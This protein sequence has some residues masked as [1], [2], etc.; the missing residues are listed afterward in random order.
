MS[1]TN[2]FDFGTVL[3]SMNDSLEES[4]K[5]LFVPVKEEPTTIHVIGT[6]R[7][8]TTLLTQ[9][10]LSHFDIGYI[11]NLI[12]AFWKA[13]VYGI[14]LSKKLLGNNYQSNYTS[15]FGATSQISEPHE[16]SYFWKYHLNYD[17][18]LQQTYNK[19][20][21]VSWEQLKLILTQM[22]LANE[23]PML[24]KSFQYGFHASEAISHMPNSLFVLIKRDPFQTAFSILKLREKMHKSADVWAS[25][26]PYQYHFLKDENNYRQI[27]G[28]VLF[29]NFEYEKQFAKVP[30]KN[31]LII[32]YEELC[33]NTSKQLHKFSRK[34]NT[35]S[36]VE[37][38]TS[39]PK[40]NKLK[41]NMLEIPL[42]VQ[43]EFKEA[44]DWLITTYPE[45]NE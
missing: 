30:K 15:N 36:K 21:K 27:M 38:D 11:N 43:K 4:Q 6:P 23:R 25:I 39:I 12:A 35:I 17:N 13:P 42:N 20:H 18:F 31:K 41:A 33:E 5:E 2:T 19:D 1:T 8:G 29:L 34:L 14:H 26:K 7:S 44:Y 37:G 10:L 45:L 28:Q 40:S 24:F 32:S 9:L 16:F 22:C 3:S